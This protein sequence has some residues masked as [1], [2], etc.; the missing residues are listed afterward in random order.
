MENSKIIYSILKALDGYLDVPAP[1]F[2]RIT[3]EQLGITGMRWERILI[4]MQEA[5][6]ITGIVT[7]QCLSDPEPVICV[8]IHPRLTMKGLEHIENNSLMA[9]SAKGFGQAAG[10][11]SLFK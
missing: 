11:A 6:L 8:P 1:D 2:Q 7:E 10:A 3:P 5:G 4:M 9:K